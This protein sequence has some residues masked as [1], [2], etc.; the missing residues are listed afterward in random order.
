M[1]IDKYRDII[2]REEPFSPLEDD[3]EIS[4]EELQDLYQSIGVEQA[5]LLIQ[6]F[7]ELKRAGFQGGFR[8]FLQLKIKTAQGGDR[9]QEKMTEEEMQIGPGDREMIDIQ[10]QIGAPTTGAQAA[11]YGGRMGYTNGG[12][13]SLVS[14]PNPGSEWADLY[15]DYKYDQR[16]QGLPIMPFY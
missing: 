14:D 3:L 1:A 15:E 10:Q 12:I 11:A 6:E 2:E 7:I 8:E 5:E 13:G 16:Q 9:P 4:P